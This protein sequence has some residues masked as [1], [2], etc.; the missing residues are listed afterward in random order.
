[1]TGRISTRNYNTTKP[2]LTARSGK[3]VI[4]KVS[5][6]KTTKDAFGNIKHEHTGY[7]ISDYRTS[8]RTCKEMDEFSYENTTK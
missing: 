4:S 8:C 7:K 2:S 3:P 5:G 1:M 6:K